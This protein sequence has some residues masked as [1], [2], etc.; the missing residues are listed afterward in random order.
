MLILNL[1]QQEGNFATLER[2][3]ICQMKYI[4]AVLANTKFSGMSFM[5]AAGHIYTRKGND[6]FMNLCGGAARVTAF[7]I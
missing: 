6:N 5:E 2:G 4:L 3:K 1:C 7:F